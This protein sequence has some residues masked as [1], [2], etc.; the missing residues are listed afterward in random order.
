[1]L[2]DE[3]EPVLFGEEHESVHGPLW[4]VGILLLLSLGLSWSSWRCRRYRRRRSVVGRFG[5]GGG[6]RVLGGRGRKVE[7]AEPVAQIW[8]PDRLR[9]VGREADVALLQVLAG[10]AI[11]VYGQAR[12]RRAPA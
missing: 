9:V 11:L 2:L 7:P 8:S 4:L 3:L 1:M 5:C 12:I 6:G 10:D